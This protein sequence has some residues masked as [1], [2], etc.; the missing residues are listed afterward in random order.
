MKAANQ[1]LSLLVFARL[2][3]N[4]DTG[5]FDVLILDFSHFLQF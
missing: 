4:Y 1:D 5:E 3:F 2:Q